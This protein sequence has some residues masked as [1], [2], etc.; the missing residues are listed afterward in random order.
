MKITTKAL[1]EGDR[2]LFT[3]PTANGEIMEHATLVHI[4]EAT[5]DRKYPIAH[6][7]CEGGVFKYVGLGDLAA[8]VDEKTVETYEL[9]PATGEIA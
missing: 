8:I 3:W 5:K 4:L 9:V 1:K 7:R 6:I 2:V